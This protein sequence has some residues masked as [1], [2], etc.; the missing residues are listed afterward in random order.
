MILKFFS[1][2]FLHS[3]FPKHFHLGEILKN[4]SAIFRK[5]HKRR[6]KNSEARACGIVRT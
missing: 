6:A 1:I 2:F 3:H 4:F 5:A